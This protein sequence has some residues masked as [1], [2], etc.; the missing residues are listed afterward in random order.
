MEIKSFG[1]K[2]PP[3]DSD[4]YVTFNRDDADA[5]FGSGGWSD[6]GGVPCP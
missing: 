6:L 2:W 4:C 3:I 1:A 5:R